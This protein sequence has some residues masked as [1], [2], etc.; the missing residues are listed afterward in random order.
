[1]NVMGNNFA[2]MAVSVQPAASSTSS[3]VVSRPKCRIKGG[4]RGTV[5]S[6]RRSSMGSLVATEHEDHCTVVSPSLLRPLRSEPNRETLITSETGVTTPGRGIL[7]SSNSPRGGCVAAR[8]PDITKMKKLPNIMFSPFN[9][10]KIIGHRE[11]R[12]TSNEPC[13]VHIIRT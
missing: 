6:R 13:A 4:E 9:G 12:C 8:S 7:K 10:V 2:L 1:M 5:K 11:V 3:A